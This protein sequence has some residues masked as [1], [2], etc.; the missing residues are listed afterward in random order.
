LFQAERL[1]ITV[2]ALAAVLLVGEGLLIK[3]FNR[4]QAV[5]LRGC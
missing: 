3:S 5:A 1:V 4:L 2:V